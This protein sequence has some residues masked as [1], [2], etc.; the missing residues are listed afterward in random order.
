MFEC[1]YC[2]VG[3]PL[4]TVTCEALNRSD[5]CR[6]CGVAFYGH[7]GGCTTGFS[8]EVIVKPTGD[9]KLHLVPQSGHEPSLSTDP[10]SATKLAPQEGH[11]Q[12]KAD[13]TLTVIVTK[14]EYSLDERDLQRLTLGRRLFEI[15]G[16]GRNEATGECLSCEGTGEHEEGCEVVNL[17]AEFARLDY[18]EERE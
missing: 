16:D 18:E 14:K 6:T 9:S 7:Y 11:S 17:A 8:K 2:G 12:R 15:V 4:H 3:L 13:R 10:G 5:I 1:A